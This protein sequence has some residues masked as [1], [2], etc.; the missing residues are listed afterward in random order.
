M[1]FLGRNLS[2]WATPRQYRKEKNGDKRLLHQQIRKSILITSHTSFRFSLMIRQRELKWLF[3]GGRKGTKPDELNVVGARGV[4]ARGKG[5]E[6]PS[7][8]TDALQT[9]FAQAKSI[10]TSL[11]KRITNY[12]SMKILKMYCFM[13]LLVFVAGSTGTRRDCFFISVFI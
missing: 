2:K 6:S 10:H 4:R 11:V 9:F 1:G 5:S 3:S 8:V 12:K 7:R 13:K